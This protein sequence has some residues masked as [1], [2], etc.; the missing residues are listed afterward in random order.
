MSE[1]F[2][3]ISQNLRKTKNQTLKRSGQPLKKHCI[4]QRKRDDVLQLKN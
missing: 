2:I 3:I 4:G 1:D